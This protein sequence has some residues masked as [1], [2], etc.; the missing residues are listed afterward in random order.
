MSSRAI[1]SGNLRLDDALPLERVEPD[2]EP[3]ERGF[4]RPEH[5]RHRVAGLEGKSRDVVALIPVL[6]GV[7]AAACGIDRVAEL[8]HLRPGIVVVVLAFDSVACEVEQAGH[9]IAV[10]AVAGRRHR[11]RSG[12]VRGHQLDLDPLGSGGGTATEGVSGLDHGRD[13]L[14]EPPILELEIDE[15]WASDRCARHTFEG[16]SRR[17]Q[18]VRDLAGSATDAPPEL[19][20]RVGRVVTVSGIRRAL[21]L[22]PSPD[23]CSDFLSEL[24]DRVNQG[25]RL[26]M[27]PHG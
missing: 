8:V 6:R 21:Q 16:S 24:L 27:A 20:G 22:D 19:Q 13:R 10:G 15:A 12:W 17:C 18:L 9:A 1:A 2:P 7:L 14:F 25:E 3:L 26:S 11:H 23:G 4:D 5:P